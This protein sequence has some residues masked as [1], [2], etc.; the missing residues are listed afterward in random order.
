MNCNPNNGHFE[1]SPLFG[2]FVW[3]NDRDIGIINSMNI[4]EIEKHE[5][6]H[7]QCWS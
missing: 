1:K 3:G 6:N 4:S 5:K 7:L 2:F